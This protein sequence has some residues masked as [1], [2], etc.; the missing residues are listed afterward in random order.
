MRSLRDI[1]K[2][3]SQL[4]PPEAG[5]LHAEERKLIET[6]PELG[7]KIITPINQLQ[8]VCRI[9]HSC[10]RRWDGKG[11]RTARPATRFH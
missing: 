3:G 5:P 11:Y 4:G 6:H 9:V 2:I 10:P 8:D 7:A 1:G